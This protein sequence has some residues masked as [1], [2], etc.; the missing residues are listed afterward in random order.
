[1]AG[2]SDNILKIHN[3]ILKKF[4]TFS[5]NMIDYH[6]TSSMVRWSKH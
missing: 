2:D 5:G 3:K 1:M 6:S 4:K